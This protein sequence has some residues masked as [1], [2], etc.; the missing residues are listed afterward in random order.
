[1]LGSTDE[2]D[3]MSNVTKNYLYFLDRIKESSKLGIDGEKLFR[4]VCNLEIVEIKLDENDKPQLIFESINSTGKG[5][6]NSELIRNFLLMGITNANDQ[7]QYYEKYWLPL[8]DNLGNENI[9]SFFYDYLVMKDIAYIKES[10]LYDNFKKY[11]RKQNSIDEVFEDILKFAKYY[12]LIVCNDSKLYSRKTNDLCKM[13]GMLR[14][15]TIYSFLLRVCEDFEEIT[16]LYKNNIFLSDLE[17]N[18]L[19]ER[20][21]EFNKI[22]GLFGN[23]ALRRNICEIPSSSSRRF[24]A[25]LYGNIFKNPNNKK[26][27]YKSIESYLCTIITVD[28]FPTNES[29][30][31]HLIEVNMYKRANILNMF[32]ELIE[33]K[34]KEKL[35]WDDLSIE[36]IL[37]QNPDRGWKED[38]GEKFQNTYEKYLNTLG[39]LSITGYNSEYKN[40]KFS[41]KKEKLL[42]K[43]YQNDLKVITLNKELLDKEVTI[44]DEEIIIKRAKRL[45]EIIISKFDYPNDIDYSLE[46]NTYSEVYFSDESNSFE[47]DSDYKL[48]GFKILNKK[49]NCSSYKELYKKLLVELYELNP[50]IL[51]QMA[52]DNW[53]Y[54]K[55]TRIYISNDKSIMSEFSSEKL[56]KDIDI[57]IEN[58]FNR[59]TILDLIKIYLDKYNN[60]VDLNDFCLLFEIK[61]SD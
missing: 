18:T 49:V 14:H 45:A 5:L 16:N 22:I 15:N 41:I 44:W 37:P 33:N 39:N 35:S 13:F 58:L 27:Y 1:M 48:V 26:Y 17:K 8:H 53:K 31:N 34:G 52:K 47:I 42:D 60:E 6:N 55:A 7:R 23:Y 20:E 30:L 11:Y 2:L 50:A 40:K 4:G 32:F 59:N 54:E 19:E 12:K 43:L 57:Y 38:L 10:E 46:F 61:E 56:D 21:N 3:E 24:Y 51:S 25:S 9:E 29:F 36:H 28:K